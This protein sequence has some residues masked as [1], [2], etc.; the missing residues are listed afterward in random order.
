MDE[1]EKLLY[2]DDDFRITLREDGEEHNLEIRYWDKKGWENYILQRGVLRELAQTK[3]GGIVQRLYAI[4][5][6]MIPYHLNQI[7]L[8]PDAVHVALCQAYHEEEKSFWEYQKKGLKE[9]I[10]ELEKEKDF[11]SEGLKNAKRTIKALGH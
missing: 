6:N 9:R 7:G 2:Q 5:R 8:T 1:T 10:E 11:Y 4:S 3:R